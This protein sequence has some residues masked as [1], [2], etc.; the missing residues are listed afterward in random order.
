MR[1]PCQLCRRTYANQK[2]FSQHV[3]LYHDGEREPEDT[4]DESQIEENMNVS[5]ASR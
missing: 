2:P 5:N 1:I 3:I 4:D